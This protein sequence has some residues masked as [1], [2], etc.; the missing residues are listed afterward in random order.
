VLF[1]SVL[2]PDSFD[3]ASDFDIPGIGLP[4]RRGTLGVVE[5]A[6]GNHDRPLNLVFAQKAGCR[7]R[8][9]RVWPRNPWCFSSEP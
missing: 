8:R 4:D 2:R 6:T 7:G 1:G 9:E 5:R 3:R